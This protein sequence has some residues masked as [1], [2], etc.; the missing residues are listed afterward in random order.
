MREQAGDEDLAARTGGHGGCRH[1]RGP[2]VW[3]IRFYATGDDASPIIAGNASYA[4]PHAYLR[5]PARRIAVRR[6]RPHVRHHHDAAGAA[7]A[8]G[9]GSDGRADGPG[10]GDDLAA[11]PLRRRHGQPDTGDDA[12]RSRAARHHVRAG[13]HRRHLP[14]RGAAGPRGRAANDGRRAA[15]RHAAG[16][17]HLPDERDRRESGQPHHDVGGVDRRHRVFDAG[18]AGQPVGRHRAAGRQHVPARRLDTRRRRGRA[19]HRHPLALPGRR[20]QRR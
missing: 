7:A 8:Q 19:D 11:G 10:P 2:E 9:H 18:D 4:H 17:R 5:H 3:Q 16:L 12:A 1:V 15:R 13:P 6:D 20:D 14:V